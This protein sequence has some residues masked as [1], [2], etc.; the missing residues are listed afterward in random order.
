[1][2]EFVLPTAVVRRRP[3]T[4]PDELKGAVKASWVTGNN[5][6]TLSELEEEIPDDKDY[7]PYKRVFEWEEFD[8]G[9]QLRP[10][11]PKDEFVA[12]R[13]FVRAKNPSFLFMDILYASRRCSRMYIIYREREHLRRLGAALGNLITRDAEGRVLDGDI[14]ASFSRISEACEKVAEQAADAVLEMSTWKGESYCSVEGS[15]CRGWNF[16]DQPDT[17]YEGVSHDDIVRK[18]QEAGI[19]C[20]TPTFTIG[21]VLGPGSI[22][23]DEHLTFAGFAHFYCAGFVPRDWVQVQFIDRQS[24]GLDLYTN[25]TLLI[26]PEDETLFSHPTLTQPRFLQVWREAMSRKLSERGFKKPDPSRL[27]W[28]AFP[29]ATPGGPAV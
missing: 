14:D 23:V 5:V 18:C 7:I 22:L 9:S 10:V 12:T 8:R 19:E 13:D 26:W 25:Q 11:G 29:K 2:D 4:E 28:R 15:K 17:S 16:E 3:G 27:T 1:M 24:S 20:T 6:Y 21:D